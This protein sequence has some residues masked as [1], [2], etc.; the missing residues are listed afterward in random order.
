MANA[1]AWQSGFQLAED[2]MARRRERKQQLSDEERQLRV[3]D[4]YDKGHRLAATIPQLSGDERQKAMG[5]LTDIEASIHSIYHPD[6][7]APGALQR[8]WDFLKGLITRKPR[9]IPLNVSYDSTVTSDINLPAAGESMQVATVPATQTT[10]GYR[11]PVTGNLRT[12]TT[13][14]PGLPAAS[15]SMPGAPLTIPGGRSVDVR[16]APAAMTKQ[17]RR[18]MAQRDE[19]RK[20]AQLDVA[21]A[22]LSPEEEAAATSRKNLAYITQARK[23]FKSANPDA[24][25]A[26]EA[27]FVSDLITKTYGITQKPVWKEFAGPN[28]EK[29][30][31]DITQPIP[32]GYTATGA[33]TTDTRKRAD[34]AAYLKTHPDYEAK[35]GNYEKWVVTQGQLAKIET[36]TSRDDRY[37]NIEQKRALGQP[38]SKD[39]QAYTDAYNIYIAKRVT[40][41]MLQ[42]VAAQAADRYVPFMDPSNPEQVIMM[43]VAVGAAAKL[44][45]PQ[46]IAFQTDKA[47]SK[48]MTSGKGGEN[49]VYFNTAV[50][51]LKLL[52]ETANALNN[53]DI[54]LINKWGN[55]FATATGDPA[56]TDFEAVK[57]AVLGELAK[58]F[59]GKGAT[60]EEI[61]ML[62]EVINQAQSPE[63]ITGAITYYLNSMDGRLGAMRTQW[64]MAKQ[65]QPAFVGTGASGAGGGAGGAKTY[66]HYATNPQNHH[67]IGT[68]D[69]PQSPNAKWYDVQTGKLVQ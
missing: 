46:S 6:N 49:L 56:P 36:P 68:D 17:Q 63:Q 44:G 20:Q 48:Y 34:Y 52:K 30:W 18:Q 67:R 55:A 65:G 28:G 13:A 54:Q 26:Q 5:Q 23:D 64:D 21:A 16:P 62:S 27:A 22:G 33:E 50:D 24:T 53:G 51:H 3:S 66:R 15:I 9:P 1:A 47:M 2:A 11:D 38:L 45:T 31:L 14:D 41:P 4:L 32:P 7:A 25:P 59:S 42:R 60:V 57:S 37:I 29:D 19:A 39:E 58:T 10:T 61:A 69:D 35:G 8:D 43:P 40:G 12:T